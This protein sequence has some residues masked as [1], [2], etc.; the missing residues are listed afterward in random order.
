MWGEKL[1]GDVLGDEKMFDRRREFIVKYVKVRREA[2]LLEEISNEGANALPFGGMSGS[3]G[4]GKD[5]IT[6]LNVGDGDVS[7]TRR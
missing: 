5:G 4:C 7:V 2:A 1:D 3:H 6:L